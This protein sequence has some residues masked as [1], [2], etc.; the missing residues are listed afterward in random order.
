MKR[1][2]GDVSHMRCVVETDKHPVIPP[3]PIMLVTSNRREYGAKTLWRPEDARRIA[4]YLIAAAEEVEAARR[5]LEEQDN[6]TN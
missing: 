2:V 4:A 6:A 5:L 1:E 3:G